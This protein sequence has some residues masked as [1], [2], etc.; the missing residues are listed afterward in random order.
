MDG[1]ID[2]YDPALASVTRDERE[3]AAARDATA[4][5]IVVA[6]V[7]IAGALAFAIVGFTLIAMVVVMPA[8][9]MVGMVFS[10]VFA[11]L[12]IAAGLGAAARHVGRRPAR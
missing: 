10:G 7:G 2:R 3:R 8:H 11:L 1:V 12:V 4:A 9:W 6:G 5:A